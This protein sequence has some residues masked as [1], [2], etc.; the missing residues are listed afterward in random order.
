MVEI[1]VLYVVHLCYVEITIIDYNKAK[2]NSDYYL[3]PM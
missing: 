2:A 3:R 1:S